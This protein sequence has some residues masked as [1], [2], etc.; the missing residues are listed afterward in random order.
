MKKFTQRPIGIILTMP[1]RWFE[2]TGHTYEGALRHMAIVL[3]E[4]EDGT[5]YFLKKS[6]PTQDFLYVYIVWDRKVQVRC[7]LLQM[8]RNHSMSW[9]DTPDGKQRYLRIK[10]G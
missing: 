2:E 9:C 1:E 8:L 5:W 4:W 6:L 3:N 7:N 10:T